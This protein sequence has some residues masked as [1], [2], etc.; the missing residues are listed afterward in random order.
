MATPSRFTERQFSTKGVLNTWKQ[1]FKLKL[2]CDFQIVAQFYF[3][4]II[5]NAI[6]HVTKGHTTS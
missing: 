3:I 5:S 2:G 4:S 1:V 6:Q